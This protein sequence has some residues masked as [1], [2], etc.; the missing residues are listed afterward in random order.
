MTW[1]NPITS[2]DAGVPL[3]FAVGPHR[4]G[5]PDSER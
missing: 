3:L 5:A 4:P 1:S 2:L